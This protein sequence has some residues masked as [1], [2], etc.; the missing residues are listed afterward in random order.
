MNNAIQIQID[1]RWI[2]ANNHIKDKEIP[3]YVV[4]GDV[5]FHQFEIPIRVGYPII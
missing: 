4:E 5:P 2:R 3:G 1:F